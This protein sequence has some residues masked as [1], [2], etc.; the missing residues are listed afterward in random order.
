MFAVINIVV[1]GEK[2]WQKTFSFF[3]EFSLLSLANIMIVSQAAFRTFLEM[4]SSPLK[5]V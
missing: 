4:F 2:I 1:D 3:Y 5:D